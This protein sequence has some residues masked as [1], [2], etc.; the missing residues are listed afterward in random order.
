MKL[1]HSSDP[2]LATSI[3]GQSERRW[4]LGLNPAVPFHIVVNGGVGRSNLNLTG[5]AVRR[6]NVNGGV[7]QTDI[8]FPSVTG[9]MEAAVVG[10]VGEIGLRV[11]ED[12]GVTILVDRG[13]GEITLGD[14]F[15]RTGERSFESQGSQLASGHL[16]L[17]VDVGVGNIT[18]E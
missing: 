18:I 2:L 16:Q 14:R 12:V 4:R 9:L 7:G 6:L 17:R 13:I 1:R 3:V 15:G 5:L 10:G 8:V 11:P